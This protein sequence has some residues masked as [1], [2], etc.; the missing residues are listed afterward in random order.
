[1]SFTL[2]YKHV[3]RRR[4][5]SSRLWSSRRPTSWRFE[6][7]SYR[8]TPT[9]ISTCWKRASRTTRISLTNGFPRLMMV[10]QATMT[11]KWRISEISS[12]TV[13]LSPLSQTHHL[14]ATH[15]KRRRVSLVEEGAAGELRTRKGWGVRSGDQADTETLQDARKG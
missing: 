1:M 6:W 12:S 2:I 8:S 3:W 9:S 4:N 13:P 11:R 14:R 7:A 15:W 5:S 10:P